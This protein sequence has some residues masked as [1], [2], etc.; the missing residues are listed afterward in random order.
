[1][2]KYKYNKYSLI[3]QSF[4]NEN[5][6]KIKNIIPEN[7]YNTLAN[8]NLCNNIIKILKDTQDFKPKYNLK[9]EQVYKIHDIKEHPL[10]YIFFSFLNQQKLLTKYYNN[11]P[12][13]FSF[14]NFLNW[15]QL[16]HEKI[17][18]KLDDIE[19]D[20]D[21]TN[22]LKSLIYNVSGPRKKLHDLLYSNPFVSLDIHHHA[23]TVDMEFDEYNWDDGTNISI[24]T[25]DTK[26]SINIDILFHIVHAIRQIAI[27]IFKSNIKTFPKITIFCGLQK[28][29]LKNEI[30]TILPDNINSG[31]CIVGN[32]IMIWRFEEVYKVLIH[33]LI[34][35]Y[36]LDFYA[37]DSGNKNLVE[38][39]MGNFCITGFD[40]TNEAYTELLAVI[41]HT[42]LVSIY[43]NNRFTDLLWY[44]LVHS[45]IQVNKIL[46]FYKMNINDIF[47]K[48]KCDKN[49]NQKT[50]V[51]SYFIIKTAFLFNIT[52]TI[53][54]FNLI[55]LKNNIDSYIDFIG[56]SLNNNHFINFISKIQDACIIN[57][58]DNYIKT[59]MRMTCLQIELI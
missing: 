1:M 34:H 15:Y 26:C 4:I 44:E 20:D 13:K 3:C 21:E 51:F 32:S 42:A 17:L 24:Y 31:S 22:M 52:S 14:K 41:T 18:D 9:H 10:F 57:S 36:G 50:S 19:I 55:P 43:T 30:K 40:S 33:E 28:K 56:E 38:Y 29:I 12:N 16:D 46:D 11:V 27:N 49:I 23:E 2:N 7:Y 8:N 39:I 54:L 48:D 45:S 47:N 53:K 58:N 35:F 25:V 5:K 6:D 37:A 59:N